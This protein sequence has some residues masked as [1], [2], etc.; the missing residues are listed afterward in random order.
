MTKNKEVNIELLRNSSQYKII[1]TGDY[2]NLVNAFLSF[3]IES[4]QL[5][6]V[7]EDSIEKYYLIS[8][9]NAN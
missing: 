4:P 9:I 7:L 1:L 8:S 2:H 3:I 5:L 6:N